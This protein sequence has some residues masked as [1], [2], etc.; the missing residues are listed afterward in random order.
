[1]RIKSLH[2][3]SFGGIKNLTLDFEKGLNCIFGENEKGKTTIM[4]FI[5]MMFYGNE[6]GS[7]QLSKNIRKK[8]TPWD[9][10]AMAGSIEFEIGGKEYKLEREFRNSNSTD[11]VSITDLSLGEK[12]PAEADIGTRLFGLSATAFERSIFIGQLGFPESDSSAESELNSRLSNIASTGDEK[13]SLEEICKKLEKARYAIISKTSKAGEHYKNSLIA[14]EL[15]DKL[16][17]S[18]NS[19]N[20]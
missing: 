1:M 15:S 6:R 13:L 17:V 9:G 10:S 3:I 2:I 11:K 8:Y 7:S 19:N 4:S 5:K 18:I 12:Q 14:K 16:E 20:Q